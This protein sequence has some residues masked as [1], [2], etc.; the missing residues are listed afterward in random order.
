MILYNAKQAS[1]RAIIP[2]IPSRSNEKKKDIFIAEAMLIITVS[3]A[4]D[5]SR[6]IITAIHWATFLRLS[7]VVLPFFF[8]GC[9]ALMC[10]FFLK[11]LCFFLYTFP[12]TFG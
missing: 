4:G 1:H 6:Q 5:G 7:I 3:M 8:I 11:S 2:A 9:F 12:K 10:G